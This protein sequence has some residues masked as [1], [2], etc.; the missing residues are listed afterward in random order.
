MSEESPITVTLKGGKDYDAPWLVVRGND[1]GQVANM[2][3]SLGNLPQS[4]AQ[5]AEF[6]KGTVN[7]G[8]LL[9]QTQTPPQA[10]QN[11]PVAPPAA[12]AWGQATPQGFQPAQ[13]N[14]QWQGGGQN[15][16]VFHPEGKQCQLDGKPLE[17]KKTQNGKAKW[18]CPDWRWN[19]GNPN[20]HAMEWAN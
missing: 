19:N 9:Q 8:P 12:P 5:A 10:P 4:I 3:D 17:Q 11:V 7:A 20:G 16:P 6:L 14:Q 13:A 18:Q 1:P 15:Q 2:L